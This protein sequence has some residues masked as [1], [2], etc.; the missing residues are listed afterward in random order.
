MHAGSSFSWKSTVPETAAC[1]D[2]PPKSS[3]STSCPIAAFTSAGPCAD[4]GAASN[5]G[6]TVKRPSGRKPTRITTSSFGALTRPTGDV[7]QLCTCAENRAISSGVRL[8]LTSEGQNALAARRHHQGRGAITERRQHVVGQCT[9]F[10]PGCQAA[11]EAERAGN[12]R[13]AL[14]KDGE[15]RQIL[16]DFG[17]EQVAASLADCRRGE[18]YGQLQIGAARFGQAL[19]IGRVGRLGGDVQHAPA[20]ANHVRQ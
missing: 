20:A 11:G 9:F 18:L 16:A 1:I 17:Q 13:H 3:A 4:A 15:R 14:T 2:A 7:Q 19:K 8:A 5:A 12:L 6:T 10:A